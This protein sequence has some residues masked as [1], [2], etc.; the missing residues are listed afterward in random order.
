M[1]SKKFEFCRCLRAARGGCSTHVKHKCNINNINIIIIIIIMIYIII[2]I[3]N[4]L[5]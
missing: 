4:I 5:I 1:E 3:I 2:I